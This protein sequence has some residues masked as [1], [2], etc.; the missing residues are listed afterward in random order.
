MLKRL[1]LSAAAAAALAACATT[2]P[3]PPAPVF[4]GPQAFALTTL[5]GQPPAFAGVTITLDGPRALGSTGCNSYMAVFNRAD[6]EPI[7]WFQV[8]EV[9]CTDQQMALERSFLDALN[10][11]RSLE[12]SPAGLVLRDAAGGEVARL[13][14]T[15][16]P[17]SGS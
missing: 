9:V 14:R 11:T 10:N 13:S 16:R 17:T 12:E 4:T 2:P 15:T 1:A 7:R 3:P 5:M 6:P 8:G